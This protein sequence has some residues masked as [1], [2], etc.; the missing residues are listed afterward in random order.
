VGHEYKVMAVAS[1]ALKV[2]YLYSFFPEKIKEYWVYEN[3]K[4]GLTPA[5]W[6]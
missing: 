2:L 5:N 6:V 4:G 3:F 1:K